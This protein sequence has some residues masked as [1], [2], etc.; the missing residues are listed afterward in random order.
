MA[1]VL[2][3]DKKYYPTAEETFG[4]DTETLVQE[5]D[6]QPLEVGGLGWVLRAAGV[7]FACAGHA[8]CRRW[9]RRRTRSRWR[10]IRVL[11]G[12][13]AECWWAGRAAWPSP[14]HAHLRD[15]PPLPLS[16]P[17]LLTGAHHRRDQAEAV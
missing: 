2:H 14:Q 12:W 9:C 13:G 3:E 17:P 8:A 11:A 5:E 4:K 15:L 7:G 16:L 10:W 6:A 1:V